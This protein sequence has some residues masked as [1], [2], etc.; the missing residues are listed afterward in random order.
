MGEVRPTVAQHPWRELASAFAVEMPGHM[1]GLAT[2]SVQFFNRTG[3]AAFK[4]FLNFGELLAPER[5]R[6]FCLLRDEFQ[7]TPEVF[8]SGKSPAAL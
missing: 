7:A 2:Y 3:A 8:T 1:D 4:V 6:L 5:L